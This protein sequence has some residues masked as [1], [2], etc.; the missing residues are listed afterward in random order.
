LLSNRTRSVAANW[1]RG[2]LM[3][4]F[5][6][7]PGIS[8]GTVALVVGIY[9]RLVDSLRAVVDAVL[10]LVRLDP[11]EARERL[12]EVEWWLVIP[13][14]VGIGVA[15]VS[16]ARI[17]EPVLDEDTGNPVQARAVFFGLICGSLIVPWRRGGG[18]RGHRWALAIIAAAGAFVLA[19][20]PETEVAEPARIAVLGAAMLAICAMILPG[21]SGA[22]ILLVLGMYAPTIAA[23]NDR[24]LAYLAIFA[25]GAAI[26]LGAFSK[27]LDWFLTHRHDAT[28]AVLLGLMVGSLRALWPYLD[29]DRGLEGPPADS[30]ALVEL[31]LAAAAFAFVI[32]VISIARRTAGDQAV[33]GREAGGEESADPRRLSERRSPTR[34]H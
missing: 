1:L 11:A 17:I 29:A 33:F 18:L 10:A 9:E 13:L 21:V 25:A 24:D 34:Q 31:G 23:V 2:V 12:R 28:M 16:L 19:G 3:G 15:I 27:V 30:S 14:L 6:V 22:F 5:D 20:L 7:V 8:G 4:S 32:A 26:G